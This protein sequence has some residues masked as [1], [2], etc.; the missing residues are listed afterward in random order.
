MKLL[1][2]RW[3]R[4]LLA[5]L[6]SGAVVL[7]KSIPV[8]G[9]APWLCALADALSLGA[10]LLWC[11]PYR[12]SAVIVGALAAGALDA[13]Q[14]TVPWMLPVSLTVGHFLAAL[15][16]RGGMKDVLPRAALCALVAFASQWLIVA[17]GYVLAKDLS[18]GGALRTAARSRWIAGAWY[19]VVF[20][21]LALHERH[22]A[23]VR[24]AG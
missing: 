12:L 14:G 17:M 21:A 15:V 6:L 18:L 2:T 4:A 22:I 3:Q 10:L 20:A 5:A 8:V 16:W 9:A 24:S 23:C 11:A 1:R 7:L 13:L 19:A